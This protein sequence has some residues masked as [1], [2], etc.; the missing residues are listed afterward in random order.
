[1][2]IHTFK[3][4]NFSTWQ[5][6]ESACIYSMISIL[7]VKLGWL[8]C[9]LYSSIIF[10]CCLVLYYNGKPVLIIALINPYESIHELNGPV[11]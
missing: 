10:Y 8:F 11:I 2:H 4:I 6:R 9:L 3:K 7:I 1:M 5:N